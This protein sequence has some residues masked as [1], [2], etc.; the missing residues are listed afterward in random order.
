MGAMPGEPVRGCPVLGAIRAFGMRPSLVVLGMLTLVWPQIV[1]MRCDMAP[2]APH[3]AHASVAPE[4]A[5]DGP[6]CLAALACGAPMMEG[7]AAPVL[8][9]PADP[10]PLH[11]Q[12]ASTVPQTAVPT[13]DPPPP[14]RVA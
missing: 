11:P 12:P 9:E 14:R 2:G 8:V 5:H 7:M 13:A 6:H 4:H 10:P 3:E 1:V